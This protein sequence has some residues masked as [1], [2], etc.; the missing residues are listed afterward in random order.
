MLAPVELEIELFCRGMRIDP[1]CEVERG[2]PPHLADA[3]RAR[4]GARARDPVAEQ[5]DLGERPGRRALRRG[6]PLRPPEKWRGLPRGRRARRTTIPSRCRPS[7]TGTRG[8]T[9]AGT[10]MSRVGV[11]QGTYLGIYVSNA[12]L[13]WASTRPPHASSARPART[14]ARPRSRARRSTTSS[15]RQSRRATARARSSRTS[16]RATTSRTRKSSRRSTA[17]GSASRSS[18][19]CGRRWAASS[20]S[21]PSRCRGRCTASTTN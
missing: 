17:S 21:R 5:E 12:C 14:S 3:R 20:A 11:L 1:S 7:P 6:V 2:R 19:P 18:G 15:R 13:Y 4:L 8:R 16:T 10:T 9:S